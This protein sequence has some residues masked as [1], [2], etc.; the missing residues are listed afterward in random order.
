MKT[1]DVIKSGSEKVTVVTAYWNLGSFQKGPSKN[2]VF[3]S[4]LYKKWMSTFQY[5][6]NPLV[7]FVD[8]KKFADHLRHLRRN[9]ANATK[10]I[11]IEKSKLWSFGLKDKIHNIYSKPGYPK[12]YP[13][14]V[15]PGYSCAQHAK[16]DAVQMAIEKNYFHT[17]YFTW[18]DIGYFRE[19][20][21]S[22]RLFEL[23]LPPQ[24][25]PNRISF[26]EVG[27]Y[28][29]I[30][31][32]KIVYENKV[33]V[34]GGMALGKSEIFLKFIAEYKKA[35]ET[36]IKMS[37]MSTDQQVLYGLYS[38]QGRKLLKPTIELQTY[39]SDDWFHLGLLCHRYA[40]K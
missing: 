17:N 32:R 31:L 18:L 9:M 25:N 6:A 8:D 21:E 35:T 3:K 30:S 34:G 1:E 13:N 37:L 5:L 24:F 15:L 22:T 29:D 39:R 7:A 23:I 26:T 11:L 28:E 14:T 33:W 40:N 12:F 2:L 36:F 16:Y 4:N 19:K 38:R 20:L 27:R 10:I